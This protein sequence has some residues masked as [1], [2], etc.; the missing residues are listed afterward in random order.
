MNDFNSLGHLEPIAP[1][2]TIIRTD[3]AR[4]TIMPSGSEER[5]A[6]YWTRSRAF[7]VDVMKG[8]SFAIVPVTTSQPLAIVDRRID[9]TPAYDTII[10]LQA[11]SKAPVIR[12]KQS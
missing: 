11:G 5:S 12:K 4:H 7:D 8:M 6:P 3:E 9:A 10:K 1:R 2:N